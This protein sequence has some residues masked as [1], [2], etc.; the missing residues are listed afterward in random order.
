MLHIEHRYNAQT[1]VLAYRGLERCYKLDHLCVNIREGAH[2]VNRSRS[3]SIFR[4][5]AHIHLNQT[6]NLTK[7]WHCNRES[8]RG[9]VSDYVR[10][11]F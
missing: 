10:K 11:R 8:S 2:Y 1:Y 6:A 5:V 4:Y 7:K 9:Q 3:I